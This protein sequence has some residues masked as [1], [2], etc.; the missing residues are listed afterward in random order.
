MFEA[1]G[2][3]DQEK[4]LYAAVTRVEADLKANDVNAAIHYI[5]GMS[6]RKRLGALDEI[7]IKDFKWTVAMT[8]ID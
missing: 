6:G 5:V 8:A 3:D 7:R 4:T 2:L 1:L